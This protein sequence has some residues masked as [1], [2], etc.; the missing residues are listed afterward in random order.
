[1]KI[2]NCLEYKKTRLYLLIYSYLAI[3]S[4]FLISFP[5]IIDYF[6]GSPKLKILYIYIEEIPF[7][8]FCYTNHTLIYKL[9]KWY[10]Y[11]VLEL[12]IA[13]IAYMEIFR[14]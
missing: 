13:F 11:V 9:L 6:L 14:L 12:L 8:I 7:C 2:I 5:Y 1:M 4:I 10:L 3:V